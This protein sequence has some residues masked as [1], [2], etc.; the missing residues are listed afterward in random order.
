MKQE[1]M[2]QVTKSIAIL[3]IMLFS[4]AILAQDGVRREMIEQNLQAQRV[5]F[6]TQRLDLTPDES[7]KF[8][9]IYNE[10]KDKEKAMRKEGR[11]GERLNTLSE[12]EAKSTIQ[13]HLEI[14][15]QVLNL[16]REYFTRLQGAIPSTKLVRLGMAE[17]AFK[18]EILQRLRERRMDRMGRN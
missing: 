3:A 11:P 12:A 6:I 9:P 7:A 1:E 15:Q 2:K 5:A 14:E 17:E 18:L 16:K 10:F 8:W 13:E 4:T